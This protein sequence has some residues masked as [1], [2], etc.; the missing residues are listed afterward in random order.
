MSG[1]YECHAHA[2]M[3]GADFRAARERHRNGVDEAAVRAALAGLRDAGVTWYRDGGDAYGVSA[4]GREL[5]GE[6]GIECVTPVFA[7]H[8]N[9]YYG[10]IVGRGFDDVRE[11]R[12]RLRELKEA[13]GDFVKIMLSG[14]ITFKSWG[15]LSCPGLEPG[16]IREL[17]KIAHG[18]GCAVMV[19][20]NGPE[21][22]RAAALAGADSVEH[23]YFADAAALE[24]MAENHTLWVP[25]LAA[26]EAFVGR[27]G[28]D[29]AV[30]EATV[31][32]Q[33]DALRA[34][35]ELGIDIA[36]GS[37]SGAVGVPHGAGAVREY[38]LLARAGLTGTE[39]EEANEKLR[40]RFSSRS[41]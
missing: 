26:T 18:E 8:K 10:G 24:A 17:V 14:I 22:I 41:R 4:L 20:C 21:T 9:G 7:T 36:E 27:P 13:G 29:R 30:A 40:E 6:Y 1:L 34:G 33:R 5:A 32:R 25:T 38:E 23:G 31:A 35:R 3:D 39:I 16:E 19:H 37:D 12:L 15:D 11:F 2:L 28:I